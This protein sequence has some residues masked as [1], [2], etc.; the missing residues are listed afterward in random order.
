MNNCSLIVLS[1]EKVKS[2]A[3]LT[4]VLPAEVTEGWVSLF[5][6]LISYMPLEQQYPSKP[7][8]HAMAKAIRN[9]ISCHSRICHSPLDPTLL[10]M[11]Y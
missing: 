6:C 4:S 1:Y 7:V 3:L 2:A 9:F 5:R 10:R 8:S 11:K